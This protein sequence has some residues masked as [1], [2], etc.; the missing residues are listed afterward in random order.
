MEK[1]AL[2]MVGDG[3]MEEPAGGKVDPFGRRSPLHRSCT[4]DSAP[5][6]VR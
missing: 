3:V 5:H 1:V 2:V 6:P 4:P